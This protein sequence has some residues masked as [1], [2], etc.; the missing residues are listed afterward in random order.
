MFMQNKNAWWLANSS[1][2]GVIPHIIN[3]LMCRDVHC[4]GVM[5][6]ED[7]E[8]LKYVEVNDKNKGDVLGSKYLDVEPDKETYAKI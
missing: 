1:S 5:F 7:F 8:K 3:M 4:F 2:G 6:D